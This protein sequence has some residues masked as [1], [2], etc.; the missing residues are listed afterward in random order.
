MK[1]F[2]QDPPAISWLTWIQRRIYS[3]NEQKALE[4]QLHTEKIDGIQS[5]PMNVNHATEYSKFLARYYSTN[6]Q[7]QIP[8]EVFKLKGLRGIELR[9]SETL[10]GVV[11]SF[12][13]GKLLD[14]DTGLITWLC[15]HPKW[16]KKGLANLLLHEVQKETYP[17][18]IHLFRNDGWLKSPLPPLWTETMI[19][20]KRMLRETKKVKKISLGSCRDRIYKSWKKENPNGLLLDNPEYSSFIEVWKHIPTK[21]LLILQPTFETEPY[22]DRRWCEIL[23]WVGENNYE[24]SISIESIIDNLPYTWIQAPSNMPHL[25]MWSSGGQTSW[26]IHGFDPGI[27]MRKVLSLLIS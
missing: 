17:R 3:N 12:Y 22:T 11:F 8:L 19:V 9:D 24:I 25:D 13:C 2:F 15:V 21:T 14:I 7:L 18:T 16:R 20:R 10:V 23:Y 1:H 6:A 26:T 4:I 5:N 27:P